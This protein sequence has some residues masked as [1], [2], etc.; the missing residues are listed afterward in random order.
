MK[1]PAIPALSEEGQQALDAYTAALRE[2]T[3]T[4]PATVRNYRSDLRQFI[5]WCERTWAAGQE[6][7]PVFTPTALT[8]PLITRYRSYLQHT[9]HLK[10]TSVNRALV[11]INRYVAWA[12]ETG[13]LGRN[14][15][16]PAKLIPIEDSAP[17]HLD[18]TEEGRRSGFLCVYGK[19]NKYREVPLNATARP[20][21][22]AYL[23]ELAD[24]E[25]YLFPPTKTDQALSERALGHLIKKNAT[26][27]RLSDVSP[28]DL[29]HRFGYRMAETVPLHRLAQMMGHDAQRLTE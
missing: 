25:S 3:D 18:D 4:S 11:S 2:H 17:R 19:R 15:A 6:H 21:L 5:A 27:A 16:A 10:P 22:T 28:H 7:A 13:Q 14:V 24:T 1:R 9:Q 26:L 29:R 8:T 23:P 12:V 20:A